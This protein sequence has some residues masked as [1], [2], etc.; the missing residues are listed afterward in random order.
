VPRVERWLERWK[1]PVLALLTV[2]YFSGN[3]A[4]SFSK[5]M[6]LDEYFTFDVAKLPTA[7]EEWR[8][9]MA[10]ADHT[11]PLFQFATRGALELAGMGR[12]GLRLPAAL[13]FWVMCLC[14]FLFVRQKLGTV[15]GFTAFL[16]PMLTKAEEYAFEARGYG[17]MFGF[18][19]LA[20]LAWQ[21]R[22]VWWFAVFMGAATLCHPYSVFILLAFAAGEA[23]RAW[24]NRRIDWWMNAAFAAS[25]IPIAM[26]SRILAE[27]RN[28]NK[29]GL[30]IATWAS[31]KE[32][33]TEMFEPFWTCA[34]VIAAI[35]LLAI[36]L[37]P[38]AETREEVGL[39]KI[40]DHELTM[41]IA[42]LLLPAPI[43]A[44]TIAIR[45]YFSFRYA[46]V[47]VIG[48]AL[49]L[50]FAIAASGR[51]GRWLMPATMLVLFAFWAK[52]ERARF[53]Y[54]EMPRTPTYESVNRSNL[55]V[56][57]EEPFVYIDLAH[58]WPSELARRLRYVADPVLSDKYRS[59]ATI[60][61][62]LIN[63]A[64][65]TPLTLEDYQ[66]L[67]RSGRDFLLYY[68]PGR[69]GWLLNRLVEDGVHIELLEQRGLQ[70]IYRVTQK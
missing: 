32:V 33:Y 17:L 41:G 54:L 55:P 47:S 63:I 26:F 51:C 6:W 8:A 56:Y 45:G 69:Y 1:W 67:R 44:A 68:S 42:F 2:L 12:I 60:D 43:V 50:V 70:M 58:R 7:A 18:C 40:P 62:T 20:M 39:R 49:V 23:V 22:W 5:P 3:F 29:T 9:L 37:K 36:F 28:L 24:Q 14:L 10:G 34:M 19:G 46:A 52:A 53:H 30:E 66:T 31:L 64:P 25:L 11:P 27:A 35:T 16:A 57:V 38:A 48:V 4:A 15:A 61:Y 59:A 65:Y 21:R 13:G